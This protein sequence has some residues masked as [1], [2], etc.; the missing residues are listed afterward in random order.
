MVLDNRIRDINISRYVYP[1]CVSE[2]HPRRILQ[3]VPESAHQFL[4]ELKKIGDGDIREFWIYRPHRRE[5]QISK[6]IYSNL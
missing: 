2:D 1:L 6:K 5:E 3:N 4:L